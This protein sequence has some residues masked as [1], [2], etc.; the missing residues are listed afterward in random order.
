MASG[1]NV[2][3]D[4]QTITVVIT[5]GGAYVLGSSS[6]TVTPAGGGGAVQVTSDVTAGNT[7]TFTY[8]NV[9]AGDYNVSVTCGGATDTNQVTID[10][11]SG[12]IG[13]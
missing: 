6:V 7:R 5:G 10:G 11:N 13:G 4:G 12:P 9:A 3:A 1:Y 2:S 8:S